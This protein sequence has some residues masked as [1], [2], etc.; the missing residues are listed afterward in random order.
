MN[1]VALEFICIAIAAL[2]LTIVSVIIETKFGGK[3]DMSRKINKI[4][5]KKP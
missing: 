5:R 4:K 1:N 3:K 2:I